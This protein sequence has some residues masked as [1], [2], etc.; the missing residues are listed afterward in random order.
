MQAGGKIEPGED[1]LSALRRELREEIGVM[2]DAGDVRPLGCF[3]APAIN[4]IGRTVEAELFHLRLAAAP[5]PA[6]E[7][8]EAIWVTPEAAEALPLAALTRDHVLPLTRAIKPA[9]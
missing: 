9:Q 1:A 7:I 6:S 8:E 3:E 4:E 5:S 2:F